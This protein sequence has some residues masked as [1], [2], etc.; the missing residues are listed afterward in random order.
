MEIEAQRGDDIPWGDEPPD[1]RSTFVG[2]G[3]IEIGE[4]PDDIPFSRKMSTPIVPEKI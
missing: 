2:D 1:I 3:E 4:A